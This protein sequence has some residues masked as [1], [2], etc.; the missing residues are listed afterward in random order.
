MEPK[1]DLESPEGRQACRRQLRTVARGWR[2][3]GISLV[4]IAAVL[5]VVSTGRPELRIASYVLLAVS[6]AVTL[7][8]TWRRTA[9]HRARMQGS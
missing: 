1:P 2:W 7:I 3:T 4:V 9:D 8:G 5:L 6:W